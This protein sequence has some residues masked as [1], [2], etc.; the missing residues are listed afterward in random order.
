M[1]GFY[2]AKHPESL[3]KNFLKKFCPVEISKTLFE[4]FFSEISGGISNTISEGFSGWVLWEAFREKTPNEFLGECLN[5]KPMKQ[6]LSK[7]VGESL[8]KFPKKPVKEFFKASMQDFFIFFCEISEA[9]RISEEISSF[10]KQSLKKISEK[11][12]W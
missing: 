9:W 1:L 2:Y 7:F 4:D 11:N 5:K 12:F 6:F 10:L 3:W 8:E